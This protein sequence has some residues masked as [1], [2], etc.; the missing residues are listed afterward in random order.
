MIKNLY[1]MFSDRRFL[2]YIV[3]GLLAFFVEYVSFLGLLNILHV[4]YGLSVAQTISFSVGLLVSFLGNRNYTFNTKDAS[5]RHSKKHQAVRYVT[6]AI[7][8]L[9]ITNALIYIF[10]DQLLIMPMVAKVIVM[11]LI[12][13]W[14]YILFRSFIF[15][16][17]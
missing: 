5:Y 7:T 1:L 15:K 6:L 3:V 11:F 9:L 16:V 13:P 4:S 8:N 12:I 10:V 2:S 14:N 17:K